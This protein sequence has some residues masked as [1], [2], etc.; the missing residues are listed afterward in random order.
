MWTLRASKKLRNSQLQNYLHLF[1]FL[2][3]FSS[4]VHLKTLKTTIGELTAN[5]TL[6]T[7]HLLIYLI[8]TYALFHHIGLTKMNKELIFST[9]VMKVVYLR[10]LNFEVLNR[11]WIGHCFQRSGLFQ[12]KK[13]KHSQRRE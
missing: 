1:H 6:K 2:R 8:P 10:C 5:T 11:Q 4:Q 13:I 7:H 9:Q 12:Y 3:C